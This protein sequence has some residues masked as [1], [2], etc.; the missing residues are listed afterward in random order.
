MY[1][2]AIFLTYRSMKKLLPLICSFLTAS[3]LACSVSMNFVPG[4]EKV[5][6]NAGISEA[7]FNEIADKIGNIYSPIISSLGGKLIVNKRW[8]FASANPFA[9]RSQ[10][11]WTLELFGGLARHPLMTED[12]FALAVCH[13]LGHLLGGAPKFKDP[14]KQLYSNEGEADYFA[15][16]KCL[17][18]YFMSEDN[19]A[20]LSK[21]KIPEI[22]ARSCKKSY[23]KKTEQAICIRIG[24]AGLENGKLFASLEKTSEPSFE[25]PDRS[26]VPMTDD[27]HPHAQCRLDTYLRGAICNKPLHDDLSDEDETIGACHKLNGDSIGLRPSCWFSPEKK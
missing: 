13:E 1:F 18:F 6:G 10:D 26:V 3:A 22:L 9:Y 8:T 16:L 14:I 15:A 25:T 17:R 2:F 11:K 21:V 19:E 20:F 27:K 23:S 24:L 5:I 12:A 4:N 7:R